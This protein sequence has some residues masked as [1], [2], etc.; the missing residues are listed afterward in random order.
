VTDSARSSSAPPP[1]AATDPAAL[2]A[3]LEAALLRELARLHAWDNQL[4]FGRRLRPPVFRLSDA[5][6][7]LGAWVRA[8][9][10]IEM[11]RRLVVERPWPEVVEVLAH[12]MAH[13]FVDEVMGVQEETAHGESFRRVCA[14]RGI[15]ARAAGVPRPDDAA[16]A[17]VT[18]PRGAAL[19]RVRERVRKL[20][21]L[22]ASSNQHEAEIA[23]RRAHELM[24][25]HN[26]EEAQARAVA[27]FEVR[28][29]G[30]PERRTT[31]VERDVMAILSE[32]FFVEVIEI[33][34]YLARRGGHG[35]VFEL[36]G[37]RA[38]LE[39]AVHVHAFLLAT[40][41]RLWWENR[42]DGRVKSGRDRLAYQTGVIRGFDDKLRGER[43]V[44]AGTGLVW[45]GDRRLE[46]FYRA[47]HPRIV[48]R[49]QKVRI[50]GAH[51]AGR[52]AGRTIVLNRPIEHGPSGAAP[53][54]LRG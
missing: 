30:D 44:L 13:Q 27:E 24:L 21:A 35:H 48:R 9:R 39:M 4:R 17:G 38:N 52:E 54:R 15:D 20:F 28:H 43:V 12:E 8:T 7:R 5:A 40:A 2:P 19:E 34:V 1:S 45:R 14:E 6:T 16:P 47:R 36:A 33:P 3:Q 32:Y 18:D 42:G 41:E 11:S 49:R 53:R 23:M 51:A 50:N 10:T 26:I 31:R 22:A 29:L 37:T 25:R 46:D